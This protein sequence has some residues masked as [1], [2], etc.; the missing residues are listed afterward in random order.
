MNENKIQTST[1]DQYRELNLYARHYDQRLWMIPS[2]A[3]GLSLFF[4]GTIFKLDTV[5]TGRAVLAALNAVIFS[6]FLMQYVKDR[7]FQL[8][9]QN[10]LSRFDDFGATVGDK[11]VDEKD[12]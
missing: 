1:P 11:P 2:A 5:L 6:G 9:I 4:C 3:Y 12:K 10:T 7:C 8:S